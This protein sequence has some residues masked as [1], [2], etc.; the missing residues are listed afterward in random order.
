MRLAKGIPLGCPLPLTVA[1]VNCIQ[2]LK[3]LGKLVWSSMTGSISGGAL[4]G[5]RAQAGAHAAS[6]MLLTRRAAARAYALLCP[7]DLLLFEILVSIRVRICSCSLS[8]HVTH[9][10]HE[11]RHVTHPNHGLR[12]VTHPNHGLRHV[13][14]SSQPWIASCHPSQP[15]IASH[16]KLHLTISSVTTLMTSHKCCR[17]GHLAQLQRVRTCNTGFNYGRLRC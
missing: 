3:V 1:T 8:R 14:H 17:G 15:W 4:E 10:I 11:L 12:H 9:P 2:P 13:T 5:L 7:L 6:P 16:H